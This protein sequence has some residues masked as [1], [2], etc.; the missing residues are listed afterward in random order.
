LRHISGKS[1][2][3]RAFRYALN[4]WPSFC[5]FLSDGRV[6]I[7]NNPAKRAMRPIGIG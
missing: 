1:D 7:D 2:L 6:D 3:A 5:L 4:R